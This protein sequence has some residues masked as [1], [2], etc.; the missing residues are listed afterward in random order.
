MTSKKLLVSKTKSK[1]ST[2]GPARSKLEFCRPRVPVHAIG[3]HRSIPPTT[4]EVLYQVPFRRDPHPFPSIAGPDLGPLDS[5]ST[6]RQVT[7]MRCGSADSAAGAPGGRHVSPMGCGFEVP[8]ALQFREP[9]FRTRRSLRHIG[10]R[11]PED[12]LSV[13]DQGEYAS[14]LGVPATKLGAAALEQVI[15][16]G[17]ALSSGANHRFGPHTQAT[18][19]PSAQL[20]RLPHHQRRGRRTQFTRASNQRFCSQI[21]QPRTLQNRDLL[22][23]RRVGTSSV[24]PPNTRKRHKVFTK[25]RTRLAWG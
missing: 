2:E 20:L 17:H 6:G 12:R 11:R 5:V 13:G 9:A 24:N 16:L 8:L 23:P 15:P 1:R 14:L 21:P 18:R 22:P 19:G 7:S 10:Q 3:G 4:C 25:V